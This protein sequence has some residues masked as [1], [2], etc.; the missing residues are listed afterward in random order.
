M[1][2]SIS[3]DSTLYATEQGL[4]SLNLFGCDTLTKNFNL[5]HYEIPNINLYD[6]LYAPETH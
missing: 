3:S 5:S 1:E 6:E 2:I 4:Y